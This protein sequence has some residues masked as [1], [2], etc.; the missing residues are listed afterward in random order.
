MKNKE[1]SILIRLAD[2]F[3]KEFQKIDKAVSSFAVKIKHVS[4][5]I[6]KF[7]QT[8][9][10]IGL[11]A[12]YLGAAITGP[13]VLAFKSA[14]GYSLGVRNELARFNNIVT[15][16]KINIAT[17]LIPVFDQLNDVMASVL[18]FWN[19]IPQEIQTNIIQFTFWSGAILLAAG[20]ILLLIGRVS[21]L[22]GKVIEA[23]GNVTLFIA[24]LSPLALAIGSVAAAIATLI[25]FWDQMRGTAVPVLNAIEIGILAVG[26]GYTKIFNSMSA[27]LIRF[28]N[29][30][31]DR[32]RVVAQIPG[33]QQT[34]YLNIIKDADKASAKLRAFSTDTQNVIAAMEQRISEIMS[35]DDGALAGS[36]DSAHEKVQETYELIKS[37]FSGQ[38]NE[39]GRAFDG[40]ITAAQQAAQAMTSALGDG[41]FN[42]ILGRFDEL[43]DVAADFGDQILKILS[44]A[45]AKFAL[46]NTIGKSFPWLAEFFHSGG[47]VRAHSGTLAY[48]EVPIIGQAGEGIVSKRGMAALG[49]GN[50]MRLNRGEQL[51]GGTTLQPTL[52]IKAFDA[53]DVFNSRKQIEG[54]MIDALRRNAPIRGAVR[55]YG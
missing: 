28:I 49:A 1:V 55:Q 19:K 30:L 26:I 45:V 31:T 47:V 51:G 36:L 34:L 38:V 52:I 22:T 7:G 9:K 10:S 44:Q 23:G 16:I 25:I 29:A 12:I 5:D 37:M 21:L 43:Q 54:I 50:L 24:K 46:V 13:L 11:D 39:V 20:S 42:V 4:R 48:G 27:G 40:W 32:L 6:K 8:L 18:N 2:Y 33:P 3:S 15:S 41:F 17:A 53:T 35:G 14:E